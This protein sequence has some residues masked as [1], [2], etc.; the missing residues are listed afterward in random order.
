MLVNI[1]FYHTFNIILKKGALMSVD[2]T[3]MCSFQILKPGE[4][5]GLSVG[6]G[7]PNTPPKLKVKFLIKNSC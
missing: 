4:K 6:S 2:E 5:K 3:L 1:Q 7:R